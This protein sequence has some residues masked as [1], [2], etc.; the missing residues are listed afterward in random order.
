MEQ[1][2]IDQLNKSN[3]ALVILIQNFLPDI[4]ATALRDY[5]L[6]FKLCK[7]LFQ[8]YFTALPFL[9]TRHTFS[10]TKIQRLPYLKSL[11][12]HHQ[13][14]LQPVAEAVVVPVC[15]LGQAVA[16]LGHHQP[17]LRLTQEV[18][19][20]IR[21]RLLPLIGIVDAHQRR[22]IG[23]QGFQQPGTH[24]SGFIGSQIRAFRKGEPEGSSAAAHPF[25]RTAEHQAGLA[26]TAVAA[27]DH[28][29]SPFQ[30]IPDHLQCL[31][32]GHIFVGSDDPQ[33]D[34][35]P[36]IHLVIPLDILGRA[37]PLRRIHHPFGQQLRLIRSLDT[38]DLAVEPVIPQQV[39]KVRPIPEHH[40]DAG[41]FLLFPLPLAPP[42]HLL[43]AQIQRNAQG[44]LLH[45]EFRAAAGRAEG[46]PDLVFLGISQTLWEVFTLIH[47]NGHR[48]IPHHN[49]DSAIALTG[50]WIV[51]IGTVDALEQPGA[52]LLKFRPG[53][54]QG[55]FVDQRL[56]IKFHGIASLS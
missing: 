7:T 37:G 49:V 2:P 54:G 53:T 38:E 6:K 8:N 46:L 16:A 30:G 40:G 21:Q 22:V 27:Q 1:C 36:M 52:D 41:L 10:A 26:H 9:N 18:P 5:I 47:R 39:Q 25:R 56:K 51:G 13:C 31:G 44:P 28:I 17:D 35:K 19:A 32:M 45:G 34:V 20:Q 43:H 50:A 4:S 12:C 42:G 55:V 48:K 23:A 11:Q 15:H 24:G 3:V 14:V 33:H 29:P